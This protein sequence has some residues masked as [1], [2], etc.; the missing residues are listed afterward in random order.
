[1]KKTLQLYALLL[2]SP[3]I[4]VAAPMDF[5]QAFEQAQKDDPQI[6]AAEYQYQ[7]TQTT[8]PQARAALLPNVS[9]DV[10]ASKHNNESTDQTSL[11]TTADRYNSDGY[12]LSLTQSV[13]NHGYWLKLQQ[14]DLNVAIGEA[15]INA[16]RQA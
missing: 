11:I 13:Y 1:M 2:A 16:A 9:L 3:L 15:Q 12:S 5:L 6:L 4:T 10:F 8:L 14:A 7:A